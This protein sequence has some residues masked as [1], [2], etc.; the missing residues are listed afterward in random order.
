MKQTE[1]GSG[2]R[3]P[4]PAETGRIDAVSMLRAARNDPEMAIPQRPAFIPGGVVVAVPDGLVVD[5]GAARQLLNGSAATTLVPKMI[6]LLDGTRSPAQIAAELDV[7]PVQ[8]EAA[9][10]LM[11]ACGLIVASLD[12]PDDVDPDV[13]AALTRH[14][15]TTKRWSSA[16]QA[17]GAAADQPAYVVDSGE[18]ARLVAQS[19][20]S[21]GDK[22]FLVDSLQQA[23]VGGQI[24]LV[25][26]AVDLLHEAVEWAS[27]AGG[28]VRACGMRLGRAWVAPALARQSTC[29]D[30]L[31][32]A[33]D[34]AGLI[35]P[36]DSEGQELRLAGGLIAL[37]ILHE[38]LGIGRPL[39]SNSLL[40]HDLA[41]GQTTQQLVVRTPGCV[42][43]GI[44]GERAR[45]QWPFIYDQAAVFPARNQVA[46]KGHQMHYQ[47]SNLA[48][49]WSSRSFSHSQHQRFAATD[50]WQHPEDSR[51]QLGA[52]MR[53]AFGLRQIGE[54]SQVR[55]YAPTGGNLGSPEGIV[56]VRDVAG[57]NP[58]AYY[59][60]PFSDELAVLGEY[61][62][63][64]LLAAIPDADFQAAVVITAALGRVQKK[65]NALALRICLL[66]AGAAVSQ[67]KHA[68][69]ALGL[70]VAHLEHWDDTALAGL[71][72]NDPEQHPVMAIL[73]VRGLGS[74]KGKGR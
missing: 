38:R 45:P 59:Y 52:L 22:V 15:D 47:P 73:E 9:V 21:C 60:L 16:A 14:L 19:L 54:I 34:V 41:G 58:G 46:M 27:H 50:D 24:V 44:P 49:Q 67:M 71:L 11:A 37:E 61:H 20:T 36:S 32:A 13:A 18:L 33:L 63:D 28:S 66:D 74:M 53:F 6:G 70:A 31:L 65:Y 64:E 30:C 43:C 62:D 56:I 26:A 57:V 40:V 2:T 51:A 25:D 10:A 5:G 72:G 55:R 35:G 23:A 8:V 39:A 7:P 12:R 68:A 4:T 69:K 1:S 3:M 29:A 17:Y 48:L 42:G